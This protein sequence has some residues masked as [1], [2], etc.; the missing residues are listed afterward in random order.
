MSG[1][2]PY[3]VGSTLCARAAVHRTQLSELLIRYS[4]YKCRNG[5]RDKMV[6]VDKKSKKSR[7]KEKKHE[8]ETKKDRSVTYF[9]LTQL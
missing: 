4:L 7:K 5:T 6:H 1:V 3:F 8:I 9:K 2:K